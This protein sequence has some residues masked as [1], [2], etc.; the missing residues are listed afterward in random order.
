[1]IYKYVQNIDSDTPIMCIN[2]HIGDEVREDGTIDEG[3]NGA[4]FQ[5]ELLSLCQMG[6]KSIDVWINSGGGSIVEGFTIFSTILNAPIQV[7]TYCMG[8][9]ASI[10]GVIFQAGNKRVMS[11]Y[12]ILMMHNPWG[13]DNDKALEAMKKSLVVMLS[14]KSKL[15]TSKMDA[16]MSE[17]TWYDS[18]QT[19]KAG[20]CDEVLST[21]EKPLEKS[22]TSYSIAKNYFNNAI[23]K[24]IISM[25]FKS[26]CNRLSI[27][28][29]DSELALMDSIEEIVNKAKRSKAE[30]EK[31]LE[32]SKNEFKK[33]KEEMDALE[34][35]CKNLEE[36]MNGYK[37]K[38]ED[39]AKNA[40][41][42]E[43]KNLVEIHVK[44][45]AIQNS[46]LEKWVNLAVNDFEGTKEMLEDIAPSKS[47]PA[48]I[49]GEGQ[50]NKVQWTGKDVANSVMAELRQKHNL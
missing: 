44:R 31:E 11:D 36:E 42:I 37:A 43:A 7:N 35:K 17:E 9:C 23:S 29:V 14:A 30:A 34:D 38:A 39:E 13:G 46:S 5:E 1:M 21:S 41:K 50:Q 19:L 3:V 45:G 27:A 15:S 18:S 33:K 25:N 4:I 26:I 24:P 47:A 28:E 10:A 49:E 48:K 6:K 8:L 22:L 32:D 40:R 2:T 12:G 20:L 16:I